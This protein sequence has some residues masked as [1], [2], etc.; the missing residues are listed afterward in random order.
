MNWI[1]R[2]L[3]RFLH[4]LWRT[5]YPKRKENPFYFVIENAVGDP[6]LCRYRLFRCKW[7]KLTLHHILRSDEDPDLHCHPWHFVSLILWAGYLEILPNGSR[8]V[9][10]GQIVRHRATDAHR[11]IL[12]RPAWT[13]LVMTGK[14]RHW[15]F[16]TKTG[17][18]KYED[19]FDRKFGKGNWVS[20]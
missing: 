15:G 11:L 1:D 16:H 12:D 6:Y 2:L 20:Y 13:L 4:F 5:F 9:R 3:M 10:P 7:F 18:M 19:Y 17:W 8:I 14:K